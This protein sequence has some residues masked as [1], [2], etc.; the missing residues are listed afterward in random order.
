M[1]DCDY[2][3]LLVFVPDEF[4]K[5]LIKNYTP[6]MQSE[7]KSSST[8]AII[9][10]ELDEILCT[11]FISVLNYFSHST[12]PCKSLLKIKFEELIVNIM[13]S[14]RNS[15]LAGYFKELCCDK[16]RSIRAIM[17]A[18]FASNLKLAKYAKLSG[19]SIAAFKEIL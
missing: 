4:I 2:C 19:R 9:P 10:L 11:Y 1:L 18:N 6:E 7:H 16:K 14:K 15:L 8:D 3:G 13:T 12:P 17:E 5:T